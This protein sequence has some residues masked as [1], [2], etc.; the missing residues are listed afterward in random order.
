MP[1]SLFTIIQ[2]EDDLL[3]RAVEGLEQMTRST[4]DVMHNSDARQVRPSRSDNRGRN[5]S[6]PSDIPSGIS[7]HT[8][9]TRHSVPSVAVPFRVA[10]QDTPR[11]A[12]APDLSSPAAY[13][14]NV[15]YAHNI[16]HPRP[17]N[18]SP[19]SRNHLRSRSANTPAM[20]QPMTRA[21]SL[22]ARTPSPAS[23]SPAIG[24]TSPSLRSPARSGSPFRP[25]SPHEFHSAT[26]TSPLLYDGGFETISEHA[27][28]DLSQTSFDRNISMNSLNSSRPVGIRR[29][30][31]SSPS[32]SPLTSSASSPSLSAQRF[33]S[34]SYPT[35]ASYGSTSSFASLSS[36]PSTPSSNRSR[37][38]SISSLETIEDAPDAEWAA[39]EADR[40]A[41]LKEAADAEDGGEPRPRGGSLDIPYRPVGFGFGKVGARKRWSV[42]GAERRADLDLETIWEDQ[43]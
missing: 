7:S 41:K 11:R 23:L 9:S 26:A 1:L 34:E 31:Q 18:R 30:R 36:M 38:P 37:S 19:Y 21:Q 22:P 29:Q 32:R 16:A 39:I 42:C 5:A 28:L 24:S 25:S 2:A 4:P 10:R 6:V 15:A 12:T 14:P 8:T 27:E 20:S 43:N 40:I 33:T 35:L 17:R 3:A 13:N